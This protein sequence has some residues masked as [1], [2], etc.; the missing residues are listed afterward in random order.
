MFVL[1][2]DAVLLN[3][4]GHKADRFVAPSKRFE[5]LL[6]QA[7]T[8]AEKSDS[9]APSRHG[10]VLFNGAHIISAGHNSDR[11]V[12]W[13]HHF[14]IF[15]RSMHAELGCLHGVSDSQIKGADLLVCRINKAGVFRLSKP[16]QKCLDI[17]ATKGVRKCYY[18]TGHGAGLGLIRV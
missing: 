14:G 13:T 18:T 8:E 12:S 3:H 7:H 2:P 9:E 1:N 6:D 11:F 17:M 5:R 15:Y 16:C 10:A 4:Y